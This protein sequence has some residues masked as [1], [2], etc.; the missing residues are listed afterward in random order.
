M[1]S[2]AATWTTY[3]C[4]DNSSGTQCSYT[5]RDVTGATP[6]AFDFATSSKLRPP[7]SAS[8]TADVTY[9]EIQ[10]SCTTTDASHSCTPA[11]PPVSGTTHIDLAWV[12]VGRTM[13][14]KF[15]GASGQRYVQHIALA[16]VSGEAFGVSYT[17]EGSAGS[18]LGTTVAV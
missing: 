4:V 16:S 3:S 5:E 1:P 9:E 14:S 10:W 2:P 15:T 18:S 12:T 6:T 8:V 7:S 13:N 11:T 17:P